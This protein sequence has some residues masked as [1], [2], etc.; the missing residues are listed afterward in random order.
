MGGWD[1]ILLGQL[2]RMG[3]CESTVHAV[4]T[5][6]G[7]AACSGVAEPHVKNRQSSPHLEGIAQPHDTINLV[8]SRAMTRPFQKCGFVGGAASC[9]Q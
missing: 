3:I 2:F 5:C 6:M 4:R 7:R 1:M 9:L 8:A